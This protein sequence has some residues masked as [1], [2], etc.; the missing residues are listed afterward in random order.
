MPDKMRLPDRTR[1]DSVPNISHF[2]DTARRIDNMSVDRNEPRSN[3]S[4]RNIIAQQLEQAPIAFLLK[5]CTASIA[6]DNLPLLD[7][8]I[9][10]LQTLAQIIP[11][12]SE[13]KLNERSM[14]W[15]N[16]NLREFINVRIT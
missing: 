4:I 10:I 5:F 1:F 7:K 9:R 12:N 11:S 2:W 3:A 8:N 15:L 16:A 14:N 6:K 13:P